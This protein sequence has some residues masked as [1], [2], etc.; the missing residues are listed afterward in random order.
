MQDINAP[1][2]LRDFQITYGKYLRSPAT[3]KR[4][5]GIPERR[6]EIYESLLFN[7]ISGFINNCFPVAPD[8][9]SEKSPYYFADDIIQQ[10]PIV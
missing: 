4:P 10:C 2:T 7:N 8:F 1:D 6:S 9:L 5:D 3:Q